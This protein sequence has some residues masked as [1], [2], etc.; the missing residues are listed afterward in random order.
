[1]N[2]LRERTASLEQP[3]K[4]T[5]FAVFRRDTFRLVVDRQGNLQR[6]G[7]TAKAKDEHCR[8]RMWECARSKAILRKP[9]CS[10]LELCKF[11]AVSCVQQ[12]MATRIPTF[13]RDRVCRVCLKREMF[14]WIPADPSKGEAEK[15]ASSMADG[16]PIRPQPCFLDLFSGTFVSFCLVGFQLKVIPELGRPFPKP[17]QKD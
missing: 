14:L 3:M 4:A 17:Q 13:V 6:E 7:G 11:D 1:M 10:R 15:T 16:C 2:L 8:S 5:L 9:I 12:T